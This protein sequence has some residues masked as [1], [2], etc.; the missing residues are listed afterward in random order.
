MMIPYLIGGI[1]LIDYCFYYSIE[2]Y[3][4]KSIVCK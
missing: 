4:I 3:T 1:G 2:Y